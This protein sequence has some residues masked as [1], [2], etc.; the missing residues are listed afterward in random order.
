VPAAQ[1]AGGEAM[2]EPVGG[3]LRCQGPAR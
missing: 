2:V 3:P 1:P